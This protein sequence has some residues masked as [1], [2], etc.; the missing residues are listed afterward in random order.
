MDTVVKSLN[1]FREN[2]LNCHEFVEN[3]DKMDTVK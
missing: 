2:V 1:N 3:E